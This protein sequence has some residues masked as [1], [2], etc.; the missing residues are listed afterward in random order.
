MDFSPTKPSHLLALLFV[1]L[2]LGVVVLLPIFSFIGLAPTT[3][4]LD[5]PE[6]DQW[7]ESFS[8]FF[9]LFAVILQIFVVVIFFFIIVPYL[10]YIL[11]N[12]LTFRDML[13][14]L[15]LTRE[16][17]ARA[18]P[19]SFIAIGAG[20]GVMI[21]TDLFLTVVGV[22]LTDASNIPDLEKFFSLPSLFLIL[23][24]QPVGEEVFFRGFLL[25]K[26]T[27]WKGRWVGIGVSSVLFGLAHLSYGMAYTAVMTAILGAIFAY[28]VLKTKNL[29]TSIIAH[30]LFN[31]ISLTFYII[32]QSFSLEALIL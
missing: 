19:W 28:V 32:A 26:F 4:S 13:A 14:R 16:G 8:L 17:L 18:L 11:V 24:I 7:S 21:V 23:T 5:I 20:F 22:D 29:Y 9:E 10:W 3:D 25:E 1:L 15:H 31:V 30:I 12:R 27:S 6:M 2:T